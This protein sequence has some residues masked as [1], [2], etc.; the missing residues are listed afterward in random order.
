[1]IEP[2]S[3]IRDLIVKILKTLSPNI[4]SILT[5]PI[6]EDCTFCGGGSLWPDLT[7]ESTTSGIGVDG[8]FDQSVLGEST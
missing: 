6:E 7:G 5:E 8:G 2:K 3:I 1:M 4:F